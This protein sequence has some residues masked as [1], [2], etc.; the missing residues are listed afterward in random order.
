GRST[1][2]TGHRRSR[3]FP[4]AQAGLAARRRSRA[5]AARF[6]ASFVAGRPVPPARRRWRAIAAR[7]SAPARQRNRKRATTPRAK[8]RGHA[9]ALPKPP[10]CCWTLV[11]RPLCHGLL[12]PIADSQATIRI[13]YS[14]C[15][16]AAKLGVSKVK[17]AALP[18]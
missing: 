12:P 9:P 2:G 4:P 18:L 3:A 1:S 6:A 5:V 11:S 8:R 13:I 14:A 10:S 7:R 15:I 16:L 17:N